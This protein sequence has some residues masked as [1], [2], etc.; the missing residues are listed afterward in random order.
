MFAG[1]PVSLTGPLLPLILRLGEQG[2]CEA[3]GEVSYST[4]WR[5]DKGICV[6]N[7]SAQ[8]LLNDIFD[9]NGLVPHKWPKR[10]RRK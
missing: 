6:P 2:L 9:K 1:R 7:R 8:V 3:L 4:V 5:W 10:T